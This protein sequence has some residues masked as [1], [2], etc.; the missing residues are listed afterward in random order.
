LLHAG[1]DIHQD[2]GRLVAQLLDGLDGLAPVAYPYAF[3][4]PSSAR[5]TRTPIGPSRIPLSDRG[6]AEFP[7]TLLLG[8]SVNKK[9]PANFYIK[10]YKAGMPTEFLPKKK[11][12]KVVPPWH[13]RLYGVIASTERLT[14][15]S[16]PENTRGGP[17]PASEIG[18]PPKRSE[19]PR[20]C[21]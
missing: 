13:T 5:R 1:I 12:D 15:D 2:R 14:P 17:M 8:N 11:V 3:S 4:M 18:S 19:V 6:Y 20:A 10:L 7:R 9:Q 16:S 21:T